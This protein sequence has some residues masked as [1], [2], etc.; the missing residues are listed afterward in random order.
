MVLI[1]ILGIGV[2]Y[3]ALNTDLSISGNADFVVTYDIA[4]NKILNDNGGQSYIESKGQ[5]N[6]TENATTDEGMY[7]ANDN[8]G[9]SYYYRGAVENN[10]L[11]FAGYYWRIIRVNGNGSI[12]LLYQGT[13]TSEVKEKTIIALNMFNSNNDDNAYVGYMYGTPNSTTYEETHANI[14]DS[15]VKQEVD[16]WYEE[17]LIKFSEYLDIDSGFCGDRS[18]STV[19]TSMNGLG[20]YG[21]TLTYYGEY[22]RNYQTRQPTLICQNKNDYYTVKESVNGNKALTYPIALITSDEVNLAGSNGQLGV[23]NDQFYL[24]SGQPYWTMSPYWYNG[25]GQIGSHEFYLYWNGLFGYGIT[26]AQ[27]GIRPVINLKANTMLSGNGTKTNPYK[28]VD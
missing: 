28:I 6:F 18:T 1:T 12:R 25:Y 9:T 27:N 23:V 4:K 13:D 10:W 8:D 20:G 26:T 19:L 22:I 3:S 17:N 11:Y 2:G 14:H 15:I 21:K 16:K 5:P 7:A 24:Y